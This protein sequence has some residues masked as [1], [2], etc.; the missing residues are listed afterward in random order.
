MGRVVVRV[1]SGPRALRAASPTT[2]LVGL[3]VLVVGAA[4]VSAARPLGA[5]A[6][7]AVALLALALARVPA[8]LIGRRLLPLAVMGLSLVLVRAAAERLGCIADA[9]R[10]E[11][12]VAS[13]VLK[14]Y[15][16]VAFTTAAQA[17]FSERDLLVGLNSL[18]LPADARSLGYLMVRG[19]RY[20]ADEVR[21]LVRAREARGGGRGL[22]LA[23]AIG[24]LA[25]VL[26]VRCGRRA[27]T[28]AFALRA[29][30]FETGFP[31]LQRAPLRWYGWAL[32][33]V[34]L[35]CAVATARL[36]W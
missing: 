7:A 23:R 30:G 4:S 24:S 34:A 25:Q 13:L 20:L 35:A 22:R 3:L 5:V 17:A 29:R 1:K 18:P 11:M 26:I 16:I 8:G 33:P 14:A 10:G 12:F 27:E 19:A 28:Q 32:L 2:R 31:T 6:W 36:P 15:L 21:R 9:E